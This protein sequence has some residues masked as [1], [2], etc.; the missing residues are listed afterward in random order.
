VKALHVGRILG[1]LQACPICRTY[2]ATHAA[3]GT[4]ADYDGLCAEGAR[5]LG[6]LDAELRDA[7]FEPPAPRD[8]RPS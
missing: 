4:Q 5:L 3:T 8:V 6:Q 7:G 1:H 2:T